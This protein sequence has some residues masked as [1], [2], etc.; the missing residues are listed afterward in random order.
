MEEID[1][2]GSKIKVIVNDSF[3]DDGMLLI[4]QKEVVG[5]SGTHGILGPVPRET[6]DSFILNR[7]DSILSK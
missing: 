6:Y 7:L 1:L 2:L 4:R 3:P 5:Y